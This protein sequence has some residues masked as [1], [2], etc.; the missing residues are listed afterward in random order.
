MNISA[1][2][3]RRKVMTI[4]VMLTVAFF[5]VLSYNA[6]SVS[7]LPD[8]DYPTIEV[9]ISYPGASP[10]TIAN[11]VVVPLEQQFATISGIQSI[12]STSYTGSANIVLQF[13]LTKNI[14]LAAPD[15]QA[16][17]NAASAQ[18]PKDLPYAP[19]YQKVNPTATPIFFL[20]LRSNT[21]TLGQLYDYAHSVVGERISIVN[22][23]SQVQTY[24]Q[25]YAVRVQVDPQKLA[26]RGIGIDQ[27]G[28]SIKDANV[29]LPV[30]TLFSEKNEYTIAVDGQIYD[31]DKYNPLIMKSEKNGAIVRLRD[32]GKAFD[33]L[34]NDKIYVKFFQGDDSE[35][36]VALGI[37]K[38]PGANTLSVIQDIKTL[39][40]KLQSELP[41]SLKMYTMYDQSEYILESVDDVKLTLL[42]AMA[43]VVIV[44]FFYLGKFVDTIIPA[45]AIPM[46]ILGTFIIMYYFKFTIDILSLLA[47]TLSI[48]FLVDDAIVVLEN[49]VRHVEMGESPLEA[50]MNGSK[51]IGFTILSMT[52]CLCSVFIPLIFMEGIIG[53]ILHEFAVTIVATVMISG[54]ISLTLTPLLC[55]KFIPQKSKDA[56]KSKTEELSDKINH[57]MLRLYKPSLEWSLKHRKTLF[58]SGFGCFA[59][60]LFLVITLPKDFIPGDDIG[61]VQGFTVTSDGTSPFQMA[62]NQEHLAK[63]AAKNPNIESVVA[64]GASPQDNQ[65]IMFLRL[66]DIKH[67]E[68]I[69]KVVPELMRSM[70]TIPGVQVFLKPMPLINLQVGTTS[71]KAEYQYTM[72]SLQEEDLYKY[73]PIMEEKMKALNGFASVSSDLDITQPQLSI[74]I[75]RDKAS[76]LGI[77]ARQIENSLSLAFADINL[78]PINEPSNQYYVI[79]EVLPKFYRN[80]SML[81]QLWLT[82]NQSDKLVPLSSVVKMKET[83]GPLTINHLNGLPSATVSFDIKNIPLETG[84]EQLEKLAQDTLP[85]NVTGSVQG[86]ANVFKQSF[87]NLSYLLIIMFFIIYVILG[88]L[89]ENFFPP[90]TVMSTLPPAALGG[91]ISLMIC[92]DPLSLY[93][94]VGLIMLL[95]IVM[96]NG[97]IMIDFANER[98]LEGK[99]IHDAITE[100]CLIRFRPILMTTFAALMGAVPIAL[101]VG[102]LAAASRRPL[103]VVIVGGLI[104]SQILTLYLTPVTYTYVEALREKAHTFRLRK[105]KEPDLS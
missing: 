38:Q 66:K 47:I 72:Q 29:Y 87:A 26:A 70:N 86:S 40:P 23:V 48:G 102:G 94:V 100:A 56:K 79:M 68:P 57:F 73:A 27:I 95:G 37:Q 88:I 4:L 20:V 93:A 64:V 78:S 60:T 101:G 75:L 8:V 96:K 44:I 83:I 25:P 43:L 69:D 31:G 82:S 9:N 67:R 15:V 12:S 92:R 14:D 16:A 90:L 53:R 74:E 89:Y 52:L 17:I 36:M 65:G 71:S 59:L 24:G 21:M 18:L 32:V 63:I 39:L 33:S 61:F 30:G 7:D 91:L 2:F 34:Q 22:G 19:T 54:V 3:I 55:S 98:R 5:G 103:G 50:A 81:S 62:A 41:G 35:E 58:L 85:P 51:E 46:S 1:I 80:P 84:L 42:L 11:N 104:I 28:Q 77:T 13:V 49:I 45:I 6:L 97:I 10:E 76:M 99:S 105:K